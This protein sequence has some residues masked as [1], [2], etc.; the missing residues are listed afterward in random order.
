MAHGIQNY[1][2]PTTP[3]ADY[4][5]GNIKDNTGANDGTPVDQKTYSDMHQ[6]LAKTM[7]LIG[8]DPNG[9]PDNEYNGFQYIEALFIM[10]GGNRLIV[11]RT[12]TLIGTIIYPD[13]NPIVFVKPDAGVGNFISLENPTSYYV[14]T[15]TILNYSQYSF[16][17]NTITA[18]SINGVAPPFNLNAGDAIELKFAAGGGGNFVVEKLFALNI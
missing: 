5:D 7:R 18:A 16:E 15:V 8:V 6:T 10:M 2:N 1:T 11:P 4:P 14:G 3:D 17:L 9:L 13:Q 12:G